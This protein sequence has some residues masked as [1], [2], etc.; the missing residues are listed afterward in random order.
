M[1][2]PEAKL[3]G[4]GPPQSELSAEFRELV[5]GLE[6]RLDTQG[7]DLSRRWE[8]CETMLERV[9]LHV[10]AMQR[11][12]G[13]QRVQT[14]PELNGAKA[15]VITSPAEIWSEEIVSI[16]PSPA[17]DKLDKAFKVQRSATSLH[18]YFAESPSGAPI[19]MM[20]SEAPTPSKT[21]KQ[22]TS[23]FYHIPSS[24]IETSWVRR[25][26]L[27]P[28]FNWFC[29]IM[30][31]LN[32]VFCGFQSDVEVSAAFSDLL[33]PGTEDYDETREMYTQILIAF[34]IWLLVELA[35]NVA[36]HRCEFFTAPLWRWRAFDVVLALITTVEILSSNGGVL[37]SWKVFRIARLGKIMGAMRF[38][39]FFHGL[40]KMMISL[41]SCIV[42]LFWA[43]LLMFV[44][45]YVFSILMLQGV[46]TYVEE[47]VPNAREQLNTEGPY[48]RL[49][50]FHFVEGPSHVS[51]LEQLYGSMGKTCL[52]LFKAISS[53]GD[54][55]L[56][57][58]PLAEAGWIYGA[59]WVLYIGF[60]IFG[61]LNILTGIFVDSAIKTAENDCTIAVQEQLNRK[62]ELDD[63]VKRVFEAMD[64]DG[65]DE[66]SEE[67]FYTMLKNDRILAHLSSIGIEARKA[68]GLFKLLD[69]DKNGRLTLQEVL[70]GFS[71]IQGDAKSSEV[72]TLRQELRKCSKSLESIQLSNKRILTQ[73]AAADEPPGSYFNL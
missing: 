53:G 55:P 72:L 32:A 58:A 73:L 10:G 15:E 3:A 47:L 42:T 19:P 50:A 22:Y 56:F 44:I 68:K 45:M 17:K 54:W 34:W 11:S 60:M 6:R 25:L 4:A 27:S 69:D 29:I 8:K 70:D 37:S 43:F 71:L 66:L 18:D 67:E 57:A 48:R 28:F 30:A 14:A 5:A 2:E 64:T 12:E 20:E 52:T 35:I 62:T 51:E 41:A 63:I 40:Q 9:L 49:N 61:V 59:L 33:R 36:A 24:F 23:Q 38:L 39:R 13:L 7:T 21:T 26:A 31:T 16:P 46:K 65:S 1:T